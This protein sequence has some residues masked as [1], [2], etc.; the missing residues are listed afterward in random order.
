LTTSLSD[1]D[2][3]CAEQVINQ[4][5]QLLLQDDANALEL[6]ESHAPVLHALYPQ[7]PKI[8][9][10]IACFAFEEALHLLA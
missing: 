2:R 5:K 6:W 8:E 9:A 7:A 4:I 3:S 1:A 10:A